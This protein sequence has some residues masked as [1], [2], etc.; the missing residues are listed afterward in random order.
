LHSL[1]NAAII[2]TERIAGTHFTIGFEISDFATNKDNQVANVIVDRRK[3][4]V[5]HLHR[6]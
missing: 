3:V 2:A 4:I 6:L 5:L 1:L